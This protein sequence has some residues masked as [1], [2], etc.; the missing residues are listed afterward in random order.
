MAK[1]K[2]KRKSEYQ[3][4]RNRIKSIIRQQKKQGRYIDF[5]VRPYSDLIASKVRG[6]E[7]DSMVASLKHITEDYLIS[8]SHSFDTSTG[9]IFSD[10]FIPPINI[11]KDNSLIDN[12]MIS[13]FMKKVY[14]APSG[15]GSKILI[16]WKNTIVTENGTHNFALALK[17]ASENGIEIAWVELYDESFASDYISRVTEFLPEQGVIYHEQIMDRVE[18]VKK[19]NDYFENNENWELPV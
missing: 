13:Q 14:S 5:D 3:R 9:E 4:Q 12:V 17:E 16:A 10:N 2:K 1:R 18:M 11:S 15:A 7:L 8:K 19:M 6:K